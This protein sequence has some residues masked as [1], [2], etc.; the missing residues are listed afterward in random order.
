M[1]EMHDLRFI[2]KE[3]ATEFDKVVLHEQVPSYIQR[4]LF[5]DTRVT[6]HARHFRL[7]RTQLHIR[8][9]AVV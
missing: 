3:T 8:H 9:S 7:F 2:G 5:C 1:S 4:I 6:V